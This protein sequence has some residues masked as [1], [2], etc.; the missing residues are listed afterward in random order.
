M[1]RTCVTC[2]SVAALGCALC[3][4][5][6]C[7]QK[8]QREDWLAHQRLC[9]PS[10]SLG[11]EIEAL[12]AVRALAFD[13]DGTIS[14][15]MAAAAAG[16]PRS[17]HID[18]EVLSRHVEAF[19]SDRA[20]VE[21]LVRAPFRSAAPFRKLR[22][23]GVRLFIVTFGYRILVERI[24]DALGLSEFFERVY[25]PVD[26]VDEVTG[27]RYSEM[28]RDIGSKNP[29]LERIAERHSL[30]RDSI[31]LVDDSVSNVAAALDDPELAPD[32]PEWILALLVKPYATLRSARPD[33]FRA[34][35]LKIWSL[36]DPKR[37]L[38]GIE[39][40]A[41][42]DLLDEAGG[43]APSHVDALRKR[44]EAAALETNSYG[45][46]GGSGPG[47]GGSG[48]GSGPGSL[49]DEERALRDSGGVALAD[50]GARLRAAKPESWRVAAAR[51]WR[52]CSTISDCD[53]DAQTQP[54][55]M[56]YVFSLVLGASFDRSR[57][58]RALNLLVR[59]REMFRRPR[60]VPL[61]KIDRLL[62]KKDTI[63]API[64]ELLALFVRALDGAETKAEASLLVESLCAST[65]RASCD[66]SFA[67]LDRFLQALLPWSLEDVC[68]DPEA[69]AFPM[70]RRPSRPA[71]CPNE[72]K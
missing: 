41:L 47:S 34:F 9:I 2:D 15:S 36:D 61:A 3:Q 55:I 4:L 66:R 53:L 5:P 49:S 57:A 69:A 59:E 67:A 6:Y 8:C 56:T 31:V 63:V 30:A 54:D 37:D 72:K 48:A 64:G 12:G 10:E 7:S 27:E 51:L 50:I 52:R 35:W 20:R 42:V 25:T 71:V 62:V 60:P 26:F 39:D 68:A 32:T 1:Q 70:C 14:V 44:A 65:D 58:T 13:F 38:Y 45:D 21:A 24:L 23:K 19:V 28:S 40:A 18:P 29:M 33:R 22:T 43:E 11:L 16:V 46:G 17:R